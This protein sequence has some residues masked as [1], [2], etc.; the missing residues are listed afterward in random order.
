MV[1]RACARTALLL[2]ALTLAGTAA[3]GAPGDEPRRQL[4]EASW[5]AGGHHAA[6]L[7]SVVGAAQDDASTELVVLDRKGS[8]LRFPLGSQRARFLGWSRDGREVV[9]ERQ[10]GDVAVQPVAGGSGRHLRLPEGAVP[11]G[12]DG[13]QAFY[14]SEDRGHLLSVDAQGQTRVEAALPEGVRPPGALSPDGRRLVLRRAVPAAE[15]GR[16]RWATEILVY[17]DGTVLRAAT[18]ASPI[19]RVAWHPSRAALLVNAPEGT[20]TW[21]ARVLSRRG[22]LWELTA[23]H[24]EMPSP[25]QWDGRG[26]LYA[27]DS[28]GLLQVGA[29]T[30]RVRDWG[31]AA[32]RLMLWAMSPRGEQVLAGLEVAGGDTAVL[33]VPL[34][35]G[36]PRHVSTGVSGLGL[37]RRSRSL[38][39]G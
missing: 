25:L 38:R 16:R 21:V 2:F 31:D 9:Y 39:P 22:P 3:S 4:I 19:V 18:I 24:R 30:R 14:L 23:L 33:L 8:A 7:F 5:S 12:S 11:L 27:A 35:S 15:G 34:P 1:H 29:R 17:E 32:G 6:L 28:S 36:E 26:R 10:P 20:G 13:Q 37:G